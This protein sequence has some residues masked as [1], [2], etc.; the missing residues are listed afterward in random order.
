M[1]SKVGNTEGEDWWQDDLPSLRP[2]SPL[3]DYDQFYPYMVQ[4]RS[5]LSLCSYSSTSSPGTVT[6]VSKP[7]CLPRALPG[8]NIRMPAP[9]PARTRSTR[10]SSLRRLAMKHP[11]C[12]DPAPSNALAPPLLSAAL[13]P[14]PVR[15]S[16]RC[17]SPDLQALSL[18]SAT[19]KRHYR[20][21]SL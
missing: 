4:L 10:Y 1:E 17:K 8:L 18:Q 7:A 16:W 12:Q 3:S 19:S 13:E 15:Q 5:T 6:T 11:L 14:D 2:S 9:A 21:A 20:L